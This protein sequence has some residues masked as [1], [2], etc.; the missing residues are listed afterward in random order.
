VASAE[1]SEEGE[2]FQNSQSGSTLGVTLIELGHTKPKTPLRTDESEAFG[3][4]NETMKQKR[5]KAINM[6][7]HWLTYRV[8]QQQ[9]DVY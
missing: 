2:C 5:S 9:F 4:L 6:R 3:L 7:N 1:E 8:R